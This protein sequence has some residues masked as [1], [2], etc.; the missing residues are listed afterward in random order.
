MAFEPLPFFYAALTLIAIGVGFLKPNVSTQVGALYRP[1]DHR[2]DSAFTI[3]YMGI[4]L[5]AF[6]GPIICGWLRIKYGFHYGFAAAGVGM[7]VGLFVYL[8]GHRR[9]IEYQQFSSATS[10]TESQESVLPRRVVRDRVVVLLIVFAFVIL[11]W[12][13]FE[14]SAN[15]LIVWADKHT[16]LRPFDADPPPAEIAPAAVSGGST[17]WSEWEIGADQTQSFNPFFIIAFAPILA[18]FW[19]WLDR[20]KR[21]P[22]TPAKIAI[23]IGLVG[24]AFAVLIPAASRENRASSVPLA[25]IPDGVDLGRYGAT[26]LK[27]HQEAGRLHMHGVLPDV[28]RLQML[29]E[30]APDEFVSKVESLAEQSDTVALPQRHH[31][32]SVPSGLDIVG[33]QAAATFEWDAATKTLTVNKRIGERARLELLA[34]T[35]NPQFKAAVDELFVLSSRY[36]VSLWWLIAHFSILTL[37]ELCL[38]PVGLSLVTKIAPPKYVGLFMGGWFLSSAAA[39][40]LAHGVFGGKWGSMPPGTYFLIF[41]VICGVGAGLM[42]LF[43]PA[44]KRMMHG[45]E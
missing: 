10:P 45:V 43:V 26:R 34:T 21:Q 16:N 41:T 14:Q 15:A 28:D 7:A 31:L 5:G 12:M 23:G 32:D 19:T 2:R 11:F 8:L 18:F 38:S 35:A 3:F 39:E 40:Y 9:L 24:V 4:N 36:R 42:A 22:S 1:E 27:F 6:L 13:A 25:A 44:M 29:A 17:N 37:A 33:V 30:T 20:H